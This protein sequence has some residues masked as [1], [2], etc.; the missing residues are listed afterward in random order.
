LVFLVTGSS[1]CIG[2]WAV[3]TLHRLRVPVVAADIAKDHRGLRYL[4]SDADIEEVRFEPCDV[5]DLESVT[6]VVSK[7]GI[8]NI[9]HLPACKCHFVE[10]I[11]YW[12]PGST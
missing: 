10:P 5:T 3:A 9:V 8:T 4:L 7:A 11:P 12:E 6:K 2:A 1:G